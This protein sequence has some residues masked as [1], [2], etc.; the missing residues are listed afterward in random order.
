MNYI[1][2]DFCLARASKDA[3]AQFLQAIAVSHCNIVS[4]FTM[5]NG[6]SE[7][8]VNRWEIWFRLQFKSEE[9]LAKFHDC[10]LTTTKP[11][12]VTV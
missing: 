12:T 10:G 1:Y 8:N 5:S 4:S 11:Q 3:C 7:D 6:Y 9:G 2:R